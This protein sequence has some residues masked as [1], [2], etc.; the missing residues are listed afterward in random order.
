MLETFQELI[1]L[2][3]V[4]PFECVGTINE[5]NAAIFKTINKWNGKLPFL[6]DYYKGT[7]LFSNFRINDLILTEKYFDD[8]HFLEQP[9]VKILN[10]ALDE[11]TP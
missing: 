6:L 10:A 3:P 4:K 8:Q 11:K 5:V 9:F 2:N 7:P 1:G